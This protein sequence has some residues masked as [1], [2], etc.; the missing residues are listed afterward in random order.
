L[1]GG[2]IYIGLLYVKILDESLFIV[3]E[4]EKSKIELKQKQD[5]IQNVV[6]QI[7]KR[8]QKNVL[9]K[10]E[11]ELLSNLDMF[12]FVES[13]IRGGLSQISTRYARANNE[14]IKNPDYKYDPSKESSQIIYLDAN[15][16]YGWSMVQYLPYKSFK[17]NNDKWTT[18][19]ILNLANGNDDK[20]DD[21]KELQDIKDIKEILKAQDIKFSKF[22]EASEKKFIT[23]AETVAITTFAGLVI[24]VVMFFVNIKDKRNPCIIKS[25]DEKNFV[26]AIM[27][28]SI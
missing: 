21:K 10:I 7:D 5:T 11:F 12:E 19:K 18:E 9:S 26:C 6:E 16:L 20:K 4:D 14:Y 24:T 23:R 22:V 8:N 25:D 28:M 2:A 13:A 27:A 17:W 3:P 15:N 1:V